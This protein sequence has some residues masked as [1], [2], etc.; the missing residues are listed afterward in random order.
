MHLWMAVQ[1]ASPAALV[2]SDRDI[3]RW[4]WRAD[5]QFTSRT[6]YRMLFQGVIGLPAAPL[7]WHSFA[8][9][10]HKLH[11]WLALRRRCWTADRRLRHGLPSHT[12]C[13]LCFTVDETLDH[14]SLH[15]SFATEVWAGI[16]LRLR[17]PDISPTANL[18]I[19]D[20]WIT[21]SQRFSSKDRK[22]ANSLI[23]LVLRSL[24]IERNARVFEN[25]RTAAPIV[26]N[27]IVDE[28]KAWLASRGGTLRGIG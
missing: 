22:A 21:A 3:Y 27:I 2:G 20:W 4:K 25:K 6:A 9:L 14:I 18:G 26:V 11:A 28:W 13:P 10:K 1:R 5:G 16:T 23:T 7:V 12:L 17:L 19:N 24:W 8:P 15:C